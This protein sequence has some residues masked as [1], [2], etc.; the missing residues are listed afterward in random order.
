M[1]HPPSCEE[2]HTSP[3]RTDA[4]VCH[5]PLTDRPPSNPSRYSILSVQFHPTPTP[6]RSGS[7]APSRPPCLHAP[8]FHRLPSRVAPP[9]VF[10]RPGSPDIPPPF[11]TWLPDRRISWLFLVPRKNE[12][13]GNE[14][15]ETQ[16][17]FSRNIE[18]AISRRVAN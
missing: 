13:G 9:P 11:L 14:K 6:F 12:D 15:R 4:Q 17:L 8:S 16:S 10:P 3:L 18:L 7:G 1:E 5:D 2:T